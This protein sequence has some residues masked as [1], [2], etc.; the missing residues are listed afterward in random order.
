MSFPADM[1]SANGELCLRC[2]GVRYSYSLSCLNNLVTR[3]CPLCR[4]PFHLSRAV[5]VHI[6]LTTEDM[7]YILTADEVEARQYEGRI[8]RAAGDDVMDENCQTT[9][10]EAVEWLRERSPSAVSI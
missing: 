10:E 5:R 3:T 1:Y 8:L 9:I 6:D 7:S 2:S 4:K